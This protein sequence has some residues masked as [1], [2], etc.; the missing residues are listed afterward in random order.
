MARDPRLPPPLPAAAPA[1]PYAAPEA[2]VY[3]LAPGQSHAETVRR[4][5]VRHEI[6][7][8]S[9]GSL[10]FL[11]ALF[12]LIAAAGLLLAPV[13]SIQGPF[14]ATGIG[15]FYLVLGL[16]VGYLAYGFRRLRPWV[17]IPGAILSGLGLLAIPIGTLI[18]GWILYIMFC[19]K[20]RTILDPAYAEIVRATP[21]VEY[22]RTLGDKIALGVL[23]AIIGGFVLLVFWALRGP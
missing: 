17:R 15:A 3:D 18:N 11:S 21:H 8:K 5:H 13:G 14:S 12:M 22:V 9:V 19:E 2:L 6:Q 7:I 16:A 23:F 20:G 4:E 10:Y 1:N